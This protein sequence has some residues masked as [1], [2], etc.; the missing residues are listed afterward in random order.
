IAPMTKHSTTMKL[1]F[2]TY[3]RAARGAKLGQQVLEKIE[4]EFLVAGCRAAFMDRFVLDAVG[5][6]IRQAAV[7]G[8]GMDTR[9]YR[10][11]LPPQMRIVEVDEAAVHEAKAAALHDQSTRCSVRRAAVRAEGPSCCGVLRLCAARSTSPAGPSAPGRCRRPWRPRWTAGGPA[12]SSWTARWR[13]GRPRR[14]PP[15]WPPR[16]R[17]RRRAASSRALPGVA[18]AQALGARRWS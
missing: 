10:L 12:S 17:S 14:A 3:H 7:L 11:D 16:W 9:A 2:T 5:K 1:R 18:L 8:S 13:P 6:R 4:F 15:R